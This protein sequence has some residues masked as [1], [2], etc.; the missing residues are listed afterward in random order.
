MPHHTELISALAIGLT[1]AFFL[2]LIAN[3]L[4]LPPLLGYLLAGIAVGPFTPGFIA[5]PAIASQL[6]EIG[7]ILL[8]FGVGLH[9]SFDDLL[10]VRRIAVPGAIGQIL[11]ATLLAVLLT[12]MWGWNLGEGLV[13]G[14][15]LSVASTVVL[16]RALEERGILGS[17]NGKIAVGWLVVEDLVMVLTLVLLPAFAP[18]LS[19]A[20]GNLDTAALLT[21]L[22]LTLMKVVLFVVVMLVVG[23]RFVPWLLTLVARQ[24]SRELFTLAVLGTA[25]GIAYGAGMLFDVS[26]ALGAFFAGVVA[27]ES[28]VSHQAAQD[29]L[30]FQDAFAV[31]FFVSVGMLFNPSVLLTAPLQV[32]ATAL[33]III[34]KTLAAFLIVLVFKYPVGTALT[35]AVSLAQIGEFSFILA[36]LGLDLN[37]LSE[38]GM[39]LILAGAILSITL[40]PFL[41][42][43][44]PT[45][46]VALRRLP[47]FA[48]PEQV[49]PEPHPVPLF[50][51]AVVMGYGRVGSHVV[52]ALHEAGIPL[53][54]ID[55]DEHRVAELH[56]KDIPALQGDASRS[57]VLTHAHLQHAQLVVIATPDALQA[58]LITEHVRRLNP[59]VHVV[60]RTHDEF[61]Q[62]S[63]ESLGANVVLFGE[64]ELA[65]SMTA[66]VLSRIQTA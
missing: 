50:G 10:K 39:N 55:Q 13:F 20:S 43:M 53:M 65:R 25:L 7:V 64:K 46:E 27:N 12:R 30:P 17:Q 57:H 48:Q 26:F 22:G 44:L 42:R 3:R 59:D 9:F 33:I 24:G 6:A 61:T 41:F 60:A 31:L 32:V 19:N 56:K 36:G 2:G 11:V 14:L 5:D 54:V 45:L 8:M 38:K 63:L 62:Q 4:R 47:V 35:V 23:R 18:V 29:A 16:L 15:S 1:L 58:E 21:S 40:N 49:Q 52:D 28:K 66:H 37:L 34:G 51:H